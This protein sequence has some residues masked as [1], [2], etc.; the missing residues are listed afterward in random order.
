[1]ATPENNIL[2]FANLRENPWNQAF[3][4]FSV[5]RDNKIETYHAYEEMLIDQ[6][7]GKMFLDDVVYAD[8]VRDMEAAI[9]RVWRAYDELRGVDWT[10]KSDEEIYAAYKEVQLAYQGIDGYFRHTQIDGNMALADALS[11]I[12]G[13]EELRASLY[14]PTVL[15]PIEK[16]VIDWS[17]VLAGPRTE[18]AILDH[19]YM[20]PWLVPVH[21]TYDDVF[22]TMFA[23]YDYDK[24]HPP[25]L[26]DKTQLIETQERIFEQFPEAKSI[27]Q[28]LQRFALSRGEV[29]AAFAGVDFNLIPVIAEISRR[30]GES[31]RDINLYYRLHEVGELVVQRT[32]LPQE[33]K[34][35]RKH[36]FVAMIR[37]GEAVFLEGEEAEREAR[38]TLGSLFDVQKADSLKGVIAN[39]GTVRGAVC[40]LH[41]ND[42]INA[43]RLRHSFKRGDILVTE[44]TQ[45]NVMD[46]V[47]KAGGIV[48]DEGGLL[49]HAAIVSRELKIPCIV[50]TH[51]AT[52]VFKDGDMVEV[53]ANAGVVRKI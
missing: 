1:M 34:Q 5:V 29:K 24:D 6:E 14:M 39:K 13:D 50:N 17:A 32:L 36:C 9:A 53:D 8:F 31:V 3:N 16:E 21:F 46:I 22:S 48:T 11:K 49:S 26:V 51:T 28:K 4:I 25:H 35:A 15:D 18:K 7:R 42:V 52:K 33:R 2:A 12:I 27:A 20:H 23:K 43:R 44:M 47:S 10:T 40:I 41:A 37:D 30:T 19:L 45:P 38:A